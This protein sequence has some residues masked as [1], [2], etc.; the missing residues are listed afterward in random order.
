MNNVKIKRALVSV[1]DKTGLVDFVKKLHEF[2]IEIFSTGG[3]YRL[4]LEHGLQIKKVSEITKFPE[5]LD[6]RVKTLHPHIHGG[7]LA[8][9]SRAHLAELA[10]HGIDTIDMVVVNLYPFEETVAKPGVALEDALE[11]IDIGG[12]TMIRAAAKNYPHVAVVVD[13]AFYQPVLQEMAVNDG[14]VSA[15]M[16]YKMALAAFQRTSHY[17]AAI[18]SYLAGLGESIDL[19]DTISVQLTK[20]HNL[21]YGENP[22]QRAAFY[23]D[24]SKGKVGMVAAEQLHGKEL[25]YNNIQ[26]IHGAIGLALE[27]DQP[28]VA[29]IKHANPCGAAWAE[30]VVTAYARA[31]STDPTSAFGGIVA[32]N[33][34][35]SREAAEQIVKIFTE[36]VV[37]PAFSD[38]A[39]AILKGK[40]NIRLI[41]W[42]TTEP[43]TSGYE[44]K[45]V[46]GGFLLQE[47]DLLRPQYEEW[48][49]VTKRQPTEAEWHAMKFGWRVVKWV[50]SNAVIYVNEH[51][52][53]GIGAGQMSR[54]DASRLAVAKAK[55][56]G[57]DLTGSVV[58][59]D[60]FFPF[61]DGVDAAAEAGARAVIEPGGSVRDEEVIAAADEHDMAMVFTGRRH[62]RH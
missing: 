34:H 2:G 24:V 42:P 11:N 20:V 48:S 59:S 27:F 10:E 60:A 51:K 16:R 12:P 21:R 3:T 54:V 19:P 13:P 35:V 44:L 30:D 17:D 36:V 1:Y 38:E 49:V 25:S 58:V 4:L 57:L 6:G 18:S 39:L 33:R 47:A 55:D 50:K 14:G 52:T 26:D 43:P 31:L 56:A 7:I 28:A 32:M 29:I 22:H 53:L 9:R 40:K 62:F 15:D 23:A 37:A 41:V 61:R 8:K 45:A 46:E 5:I